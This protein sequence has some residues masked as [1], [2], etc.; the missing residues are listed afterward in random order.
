MGDNVRHKKVLDLG[1][2]IIFYDTA[3]QCLISL[4]MRWV[5]TLCPNI[6]LI[7]NTILLYGMG[8]E[9]K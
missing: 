2:L 5:A 7:I 6:M 4:V 1:I 3:G 8:Q 9:V